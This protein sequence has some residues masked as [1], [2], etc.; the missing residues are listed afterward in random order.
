MIVAKELK[1]PRGLRR[2]ACTHLG[3]R[4]RRTVKQRAHCDWRPRP[5]KVLVGAADFSDPA[6]RANCRNSRRSSGC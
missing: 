5:D 2:S 1:T 3:R 4:G 6:S